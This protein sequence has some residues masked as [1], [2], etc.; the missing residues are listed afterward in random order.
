MAENLD[1]SRVRPENK[2]KILKAQW[3]FFL[4]ALFASLGSIMLGFDVVASGQMLALVSSTP[5]E[6][7]ADQGCIPT[8][9]WYPI[10][11]S[12]QR[13]FGSSDMAERLDGSHH[14]RDLFWRFIF[15]LGN[16][17]YRKEAY[18]LDWKLYKYRWRRYDASQFRMETLSQRPCT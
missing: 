5:L 18:D 15:R 3:R 14:W 9:I 12:T 8:A 7:E 13:V 4:W 17:L 16:E 6:A 1:Y 10:S 11:F 2:W